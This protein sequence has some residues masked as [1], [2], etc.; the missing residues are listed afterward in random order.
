MFKVEALP[1]RT[2]KLHKNT[3]KFAQNV[4]VIRKIKNKN[5]VKYHTL[6]W[7]KFKG[8]YWEGCGKAK[9]FIHYWW[10]CYVYTHNRKQFGSFL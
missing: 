7:L 3:H 4:L 1:Q 5:I 10:E 2:Y 6:E 9:T 8:I